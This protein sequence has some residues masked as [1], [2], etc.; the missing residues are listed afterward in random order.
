MTAQLDETF[1][2]TVEEGAQRLGRS[3][4]ELIAT[5]LV[6]GVDIS[7]G[8]FALLVVEHETGN[9][10]LGALALSI[11]FIALTLASSELFTENLLVPITALAA[12]RAGPRAVAR[13]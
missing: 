5:G 11:G 10:L 6:G 7:V 9:V 3:W 8:V 2:R 4:P 1:E 12:G 13:L